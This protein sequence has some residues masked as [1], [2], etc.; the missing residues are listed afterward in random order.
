MVLEVVRDERLRIVARLHRLS[1]EEWDR[2]TPCAGWTV[3]HVLAHLVT[4]F[5][6]SAPAM[7]LA[8]V[9][10]RSVGRAI[11]AAAQRLAAEHEPSEL[12]HRLQAHATSRFRPPGLP[13]TA[14]LT[15]AVAHSAD[16][17]VALGDPLEDWSDPARLRPVLDFLVGRRAAAGFVPPG[18]LRGL[19][20][21]AEDAG[22]RHGDG[23]E[24]RGPALLVALAALGR[25][26]ALPLVEG[27][28]VPLLVDRLGA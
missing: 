28:G 4:P 7:G 1:P 15:D 20:L 12:L 22:W 24:V 25:Q 13:L 11:D 5:S 18:R 2:P 8:F 17:R 26:P 9:R 6:V 21:V 19:A 16:L 10:H 23:P 3:R 27:E 14:P